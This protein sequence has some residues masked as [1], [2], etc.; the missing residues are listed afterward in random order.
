MLFFHSICK[1]LHLLIPNSQSMSPHQHTHSATASLFS[2]SV[3][4]FYFIDKF[5][6]VIFEI[7]HISDIIWYLFFSFWLHLVWQS[8]GPS[9]LLQMALFHLFFYGWTI[10]HCVYIP[11][12]PYPFICWWTLD[13]FLFLA[14][15]N[16]AAVNIGVC[17]FFHEMINH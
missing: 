16:N 8:L 10:F 3:N 17:V 6:C 12:L 1:S 13:C 9:T 5:I 14:I 15:I 11:Y 7:A 4:L 2:M